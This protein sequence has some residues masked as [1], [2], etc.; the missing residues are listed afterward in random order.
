MRSTVTLDSDVNSLIRQLMRERQ[1]TFK[2]A[3]NQAIRDGIRNKQVRRGYR[4]PEF[5]MGVRP[6]ISL[7]H[8]LALAAAMD[9][10]E[11]LRELAARK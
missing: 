9:D 6:D 10:D 7:D 2:E 3:I 1:L 8:A 11:T 5:R 4:V